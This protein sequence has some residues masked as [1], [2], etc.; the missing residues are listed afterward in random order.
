MKLS[1][2][3]TAG[4]EA[5]VTPKGW[6]VRNNR[7]GDKKNFQCIFLC[8]TNWSTGFTFWCAR[9]AHF[10]FIVLR[11][12]ASSTEGSFTLLRSR[13]NSEMLEVV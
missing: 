8:H 7:R 5:K 3:L 13:R 11:K 4:S 6:T 10:F 9:S 1:F 2:M 12:H